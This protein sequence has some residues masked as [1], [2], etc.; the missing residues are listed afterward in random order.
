V[1]KEIREYFI[2]ET[3]LKKVS[4]KKGENGDFCVSWDLKTQK[5]FATRVP[6]YGAGREH[7]EKLLNAA[8]L[9]VLCGKDFLLANEDYANVFANF[10]NAC[11]NASDNW[12]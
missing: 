5:P 2:V 11:P 8:F 9:C 3:I 7:R 1:F 10:V 6:A 12:F 4:H